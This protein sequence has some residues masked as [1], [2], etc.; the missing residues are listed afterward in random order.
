MTPMDHH[1]RPPLPAAHARRADPDPAN[2][3]LPFAGSSSEYY[4]Q[5]QHGACGQR[6]HLPR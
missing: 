1:N 2:V 6:P 3:L 5:W 4:R